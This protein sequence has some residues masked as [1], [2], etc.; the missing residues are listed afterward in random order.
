MI[1][2]S[3]SHRSKK[4]SFNDAA[5]LLGHLQEI[6]QRV[7]ESYQVEFLALYRGDLLIQGEHGPTTAAFCRPR[8]APGC[9]ESAV[10]R[11]QKNVLGLSSAQD[12]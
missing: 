1:C 9:G 3:W 5:L 2:A 12:A 6:L 4:R 8:M 10:P 11:S 7:I